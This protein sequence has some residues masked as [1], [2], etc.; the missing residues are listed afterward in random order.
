MS[1][2]PEAEQAQLKDEARASLQALQAATG[3][4][5]ARLVALRPVADGPAPKAAQPKSARSRKTHPRR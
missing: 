4:W 5:L 1:S 3:A 2:L